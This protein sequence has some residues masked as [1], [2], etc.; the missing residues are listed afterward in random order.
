MLQILTAG[1]HV[2][3]VYRYI[4]DTH[5]AAVLQILTQEH[6]YQKYQDTH[7]A[8]VLQILTAGT[9]V[10]EVYRYVQDTLAAAVLQI[11]TAGTHVSEVSGY[12]CCSSASDFNA[13]SKPSLV[14][15]SRI[16]IW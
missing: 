14:S 4:Q 7:A 5:A 3:E 1:T 11:L 12:S 9:H 10:S 6:M 13:G 16:V 15:L 8:T 2:S